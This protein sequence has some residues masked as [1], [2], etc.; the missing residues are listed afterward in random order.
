[1]TQTPI[2]VTYSLEE[3]LSQISQKL[4]RMDTKFEHKLDEIRKDMDTKF[5]KIDTKFE[6]LQ[7]DI[8]EI[9]LGQVQM[10]EEVRGTGKRLDMQEL[11]SRSV[12]VG[13]ILSLVAG[14]LKLFL[15][16][17]LS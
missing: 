3:V 4:D 12:V 8:V 13:L 7:K 10:E 15:P 11:I 17:I 2:T 1:M 9:K 14:I 16:N 6:T 5:E